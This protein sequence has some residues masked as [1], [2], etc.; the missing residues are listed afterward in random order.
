MG[1][2][3][4][5]RQ[6]HKATLTSLSGFEVTILDIGATLQSIV[7]P[8]PSGPVNCILGYDN[9]D[10]Y[11]LDQFYVGS[12]VGR[13]AGRIRGG[14]FRLNDIQYQLNRNESSTGNCLHGGANGFHRQRF[15]LDSR[16]R[17]DRV[18]CFLTSD[19]G[20]EGFP[21]SIA[22]HVA[23]Q[24]LGDFALAIEFT[25]TADADTVINLAN[26]AYF[27][28]DRDASR[29]DSHSLRVFADRY[30]P[31]DDANI[32]TGELADV[33]N[34]KFD[35]RKPSTLGSQCYDHHFVAD[36]PSG[37]LRPVAELY[38]PNSNIRL[39]LSSTQP[40]LQVYSGDYLDAPFKSRQGIALEAQGFP[41][42]PNQAGFPSTRLAP[43]DTYVQRTI[44][45][46]SL[47]PKMPRG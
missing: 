18:D 10:N 44:Y 40:G 26:H 13:Y 28:L 4:E 47:A 45:D 7:V 27:N 24:L 41:D 39:Q 1:D 32:P 8:T 38:S 29:V 20:A 46:F 42:A 15:D 9:P 37:N 36:G 43:G 16:N 34:T 3:D 21:A 17:S 19:A 2:V 11:L 22:V 12:T 23:Y 30:S 6:V 31:L 25:A 33:D 5:T 35:L 14:R